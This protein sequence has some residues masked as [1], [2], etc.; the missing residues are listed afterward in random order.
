MCLLYLMMRKIFNLD[1]TQ[2]NS[3]CMSSRYFGWFQNPLIIYQIEISSCEIL[4]S[5][6]FTKLCLFLKKFK[7]SQF[8]EPNGFNY[9]K[10]SSIATCC[11]QNI[12]FVHTFVSRFYILLSK[13]HFF[14][15]ILH[16]LGRLSN[17]LL[18]KIKYLYFA[19]LN[20]TLE[21]HDSKSFLAFRYTIFSS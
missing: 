6:R 7:N 12:Q 3:Y 20:V 14:L 2:F 11:S 17:T 8:W 10:D 1:P 13:F 21:I 4:I 5:R 16:Y 15:I 19:I 18:N 9:L